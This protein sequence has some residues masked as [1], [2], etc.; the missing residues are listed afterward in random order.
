[1]AATVSQVSTLPEGERFY[2]LRSNAMVPLVP[3]D[4]LPFQLR[5]LPRQ[6][7]HRQMSDENWKLLHETNKPA[8]SFAIRA[9]DNIPH[10]TST[11]TPTSHSRFFAP[12]HFV[13]SYSQDIK[14]EVAPVNRCCAPPN[15]HRNAAFDL[16]PPKSTTPD[17][18]ASLSD[19]FASIH[20]QDAQRFGYH[21]PC[22]SGIKPDHSKKEFCTHW[23]QTG[24]CAFT[25]VGC[26]Y[27]HEMP[28][29]DKLR[30]LGFTQMPKW[31]KEESTI[32]ARGPTWMQLRLAGG[33]K[34]S[35]E[36]D[37]M[38]PPR[39]FRD[40]SI[41]RNR[42]VTPRDLPQR[43]P[44]PRSILQK[45]VTED[46]PSSLTTAP[47]MPL[48][49]APHE[50]QVSN[51]LIDFEETFAPPSSP[52]LSCR[53]SIST[54]TSDTQH[55]SDSTSKSSPPSSLIDEPVFTATSSD[56]RIEES[57]PKY[58]KKEKLRQPITRRESL[59]SLSSSAEGDCAPIKRMIKHANSP[60]RTSSCADTSVKQAGLATSR[61]AA[62][63]TEPCAKNVACKPTPSERKKSGSEQK[64]SHGTSG[65]T[66][67]H[68]RGRA[69][70]RTASAVE[71][72]NGGTKRVVG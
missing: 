50:G 23:I 12:D 47:P 3:V 62:T 19:T 15:M 48:T 69:G 11:P 24:E 5:G 71:P 52:Q 20:Q 2:L 70:R 10:A 41:F 63:N 57:K 40:P 14:D 58:K 54:E 16:Y 25:S 37:E 13:R 27:K 42:Q 17:C 44:L 36:L 68:A 46:T 28:A 53:S 51:L 33:K 26:K 65:R 45:L 30:Q 66:T 29:I 49:S 31:W 21:T 61:H 32:T 35:N 22:P 34:D 64:P 56:A 59:P 39:A 67:V 1:M 60:R 18:P 6:L 72:P 8:T 4:Q 9:P 7:S 55:R 43:T 38:P